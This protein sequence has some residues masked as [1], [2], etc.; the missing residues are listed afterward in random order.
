MNRRGEVQ[1]PRPFDFPA[2]NISQVRDIIHK[3]AAGFE[4]NGVKCL[5]DHS[6]HVVM[7]VQEQIYSG[8]NGEGE[9][10]AP[11]Y[12]T[13]P[14]FNE[15]G[16][17]K[18]RAKD[19]QAWK[20]SITPPAGSTLLGLPPRPDDV[21]NLYINGKFFSEITASRKG[22]VLHTD[23]GNGDGPDI[24]AKYGDSLLNLG[25]SAVEWFNADFLKPSL[26]KFYRKCG[27][28]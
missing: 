3:I 6:G 14:Y 23:P 7:A 12:L 13:D 21:P 16:Y 17:W 1:K 26:E 18:G 4:E 28:R 8:Q 25:P 15:E 19:Y 11:T 24:E 2:M 9:L 27:Y 22:D 5:S 10:L 20:K